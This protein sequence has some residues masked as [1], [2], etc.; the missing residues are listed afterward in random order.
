MSML[1]LSD[2]MWKA[3]RV[4]LFGPASLGENASV[5]R[6]N[7][8]GNLWGVRKVTPGFFAFTAVMIQFIL[9]GDNTL[10]MKGEKSKPFVGKQPLQPPQ[11]TGFQGNSQSRCRAM[12]Q[13]MLDLTLGPS[14]S[15]SAV[16]EPAAEV[17][18][19]PIGDDLA[20]LTRDDMTVTLPARDDTITLPA[21]LEPAAAPE[22]AASSTRGCSRARGGAGTGAGGARRSTRTAPGVEA[23]DNE[24]EVAAL[25]T[26][27]KQAPRKKK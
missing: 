4:T 11:R 25:P 21:A 14:S 8:V 18:E 27:P 22:P 24:E 10:A 12:S 3:M 26:K 13:A 2:Y 23:N 1:F 9:N 16:P 5:V 7:L 17:A 19:S 6:Q 15:V 20:A